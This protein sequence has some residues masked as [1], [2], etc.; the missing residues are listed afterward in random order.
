[1]G[2]F[3]LAPKER[4]TNEIEED[5]QLGA[6]EVREPVVHDLVGYLCVI[7]FAKSFRMLLGFGYTRGV[8]FHFDLP[9]RRP[10]RGATLFSREESGISRI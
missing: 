9:R 3:T 5:L 7:G 1:M 4:P 8:R 2:N 6:G 10:P